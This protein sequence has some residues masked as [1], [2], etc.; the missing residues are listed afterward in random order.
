M[1]DSI[2]LNNMLLYDIF[3]SK[4]ITPKLITCKDS[5]K[6]IDYGR[7]TTDFFNY[8]L[9]VKDVILSF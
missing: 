7:Q 6:S 1:K 5:E 4:N 8:K 9:G 2:L 3:P